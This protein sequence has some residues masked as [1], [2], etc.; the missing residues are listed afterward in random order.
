MS[1]RDD[2]VGLM[3]PLSEEDPCGADLTYDP[4]FLELQRVAEGQPER[5]SGDETKPAEPPDWDDVASRATAI[6]GRARDVRAAVLLTRAWLAEEGLEGMAS[7]LELVLGL[8]TQFWD[9]VHPRADEDG[10]LILRFNTLRTLT[11]EGFL[12]D[13]LRH[14]TL[15]D[16]GATGRMS[17]RD[18]RIVSGKIKPTED[19]PADEVPD[20]ARLD[21]AVAAATPDDLQRGLEAARRCEA[22]ASGIQNLVDEKAPGFGPDLKMLRGDLAEIVRLYEECVTQRSGGQAI[23]DGGD[24]M[25]GGGG[26]GESGGGGVGGPIRSRDD[27]IRTLDA[28]CAYYAQREPSSPVPILL[29]RAKRLVNMTF[30]DIIRDMTPSG[31]NEAQMYAGQDGGG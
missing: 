29:N 5:V 16:G 10:D 31:V 11:D 15:V 18:V 23:G 14:L 8:S 27:V 17:L 26:G 3:T 24:A 4:E 1:S 21:S 25:S 7:G 20:R 13:A 28:V 30:L 22:A 2:I 12:L 19:T 6:L 9:Q